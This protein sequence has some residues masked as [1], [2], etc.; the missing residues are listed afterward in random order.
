MQ[1]FK[2]DAFEDEWFNC[3]FGKRGEIWCIY[4][5]PLNQVYEELGITH[6]ITLMKTW[7]HP[8]YQVDN[9]DNENLESPIVSS[10]FVH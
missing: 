4:F 7:N 10:G 8:L 2:I 9:D 6:Y 3:Y 1:L 5:N